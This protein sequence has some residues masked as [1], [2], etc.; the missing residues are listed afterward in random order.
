MI[1]KKILLF[2]MIGLGLTSAEVDLK[3]FKLHG[4]GWVDIGRMGRSSDSLIFNGSTNSFSS[5]NMNISGTNF[6][7][8]GAQFSAIA[9]FSSHLEGE[10]GFGGYRATHSLGTTNG[11]Y[12]PEYIAIS[13]TKNFLTSARLTYY[14]GEKASPNFSATIGDFAYDYNPDVKNLGLYLL[15]GPVYPGIL[16]GGFQ[17][18]SIDST[19]STMM[20][21]HLHQSLGVFSHDLIF[22]NEYDLPPTFDWSLGYIAKVKTSEAFQIGAGINF[23]RLIPYDS[24]LETPGNLGF[25]DTAR[26]Y[27]TTGSNGD[28]SKWVLLS[29]QGIKAMGMFTFDINKILQI[30]SLGPN[31][32]KLY[33]EAAIIGLKNYGNVYS[34]MSERIPVMLGFN[35]PVF[36]LLDFFSIEGEWYG[37]KYRNDLGNIGNLNGV[38]DWTTQNRPVPSPLPVPGPYQDS[39]ADNIKWSVNAEKKFLGHIALQA[40]VAND[41][42][43]PR[44]I[45]SGYITAAGGT[46]EAFTNPR[47]WYAM[48]RTTYF[49]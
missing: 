35:L 37:A 48:F 27:D 1:K 10:F 39:T 29:H 34:K 14:Q 23:Y 20:G 31:D 49:F 12:G 25:L 22:K 32:L 33:G 46:A 28:R 7:S 6:E 45:S 41:H 16:M 47:D 21:I 42:Y 40:Q 2:G 19:K 3:E 17:D 24:K 38:A 43:R 9:D 8:Y 44:P 4:E 15:R 36:G 18:F 5:V 30:K 11:S 13:L 26:Y